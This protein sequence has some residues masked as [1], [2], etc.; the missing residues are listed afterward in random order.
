MKKPVEIAASAL[1]AVSLLAIPVG[2]ASAETTE[3]QKMTSSK[4]VL[5]DHLSESMEEEE[6]NDSPS[7]A[8]QVAPGTMVLGDLTD[9]DV[10]YYKLEVNGDQAVDFNLSFFAVDDDFITE[11]EMNADVMDRDGNEVDAYYEQSDEYG[12][13]GLYTLEPGVYY[14]KATDEA[15][16]D[17]GETYALIPDIYEKEPMI[18]RYYGEDRYETAANIARL[19]AD[20]H[21]SENVVLA[22]GQDFPDALAGAPL[23]EQ[24]DAPILLTRKA[25]LPAVT[26]STLSE[27]ETEHVT[28]LGG[29]GAVSQNVEDYLKEELSLSV[30]R[31]AGKNRYETA[32]AIA[33][34]LPSSNKAVVAYGKNF[35]DALSIAP[36]AAGQTMPILLTDKERVPAATEEALSNYSQ[37]YVVGGTGVISEDVFRQMPDADRISGK[38]RY[39]TSLAVVEYFDME[40][41][42]VSLATGKNFADALAGSVFSVEDPLLLT[43]KDHLNPAIK[44]YLEQKQTTYYRIFGGSAAVGEGVVRDIWSIYE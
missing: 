29:T 12:Y 1:L 19:D 6:P 44:S 43:P 41:Q 30:D 3:K 38:D 18:N 25:S 26:K 13:G 21:P 8:N 39:A 7:Q 16:L 40:A 42:S 4:V 9:Q 22:T 17:T 31:I 23:A 32:A 34:T 15:N 2:Q 24:L 20:R 37:S 11:M 5:Q 28:I 35:P 36:V 33:E 27:L 10:D 14:I